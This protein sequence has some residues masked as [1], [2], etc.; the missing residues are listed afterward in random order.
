MS[1]MTSLESVGFQLS[2]LTEGDITSISP[3]DG[4]ILGRVSSCD[5]TQVDNA[6]DQ[7]AAAF[8]AWRRVPAPR[9][10]ELVRL[11]GEAVEH[12]AAHRADDVEAVR[13]ATRERG[14]SGESGDRGVGCRLWDLDGREY[15]DLCCSHGATLL[16]HGDSRIRR[17][18]EALA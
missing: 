17:A 2:R 11:F 12:V 5:Q 8:R 18:I 14:E 16:G 13:V 6:I 7:S 1:T 3:I 15:I 4:R 9:R 10:G